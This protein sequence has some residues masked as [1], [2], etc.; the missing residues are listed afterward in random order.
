MGLQGEPGIFSAL[1]RGLLSLAQRKS[2]KK[3]SS[4]PIQICRRHRDR[5]FSTRHPC[6]VEKRQT[7]CLPPSGSPI[8][9]LRIGSALSLGRIG[10]EQ[11][12]IEPQIR[13]S[14]F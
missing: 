5:D 12:S 14:W 4:S 13:D 6:L 2:P 7:S 10:T 3:T 9:G 1:A 8:P 11:K